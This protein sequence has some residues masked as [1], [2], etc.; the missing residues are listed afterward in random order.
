M[1]VKTL[2][3]YCVNKTVSNIVLRVICSR[4]TN[5]HIIMIHQESKLLRPTKNITTCLLYNIL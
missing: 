3:Q 5:N 2:P 4:L 1:T